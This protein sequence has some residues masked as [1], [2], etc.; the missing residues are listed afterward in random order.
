MIRIAVRATDL[1]HTEQKAL[2]SCM[3]QHEIMVCKSIVCRNTV[4]L[5]SLQSCGL[6]RR[7]IQFLVAALQCN[8]NYLTELHLLGNNLDE[9]DISP[10]VELR[11]KHPY[12]LEIIE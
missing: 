8:P 5:S 9:S 6:S 10:L 1:R 2:G 12:V 4:F 3:E 11:R 7:S